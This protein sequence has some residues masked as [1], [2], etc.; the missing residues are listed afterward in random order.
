MFSVASTAFVRRRGAAAKQSVERGEA[1]PAERLAP[2][3]NRS[4]TTTR[5]FATRG[6]DEIRTVPCHALGC[7]FSHVLFRT[8]GQRHRQ[9]LVDVALSRCRSLVLQMEADV[10]LRPTETALPLC[11][12]VRRRVPGGRGRRR[13]PSS[14]SCPV[15]LSA[16]AP[17][18]LS[19]RAFRNNSPFMNSRRRRQ[20]LRRALIR[21]VA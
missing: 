20:F 3:R 11:R 5:A 6:S 7:I 10:P 9:G 16:L 14:S 19:A 17:A 8:S 4:R 21:G 2:P 15:R 12:F 13:L 18:R 1:A